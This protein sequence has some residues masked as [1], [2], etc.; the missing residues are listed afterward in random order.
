MSVK[1][2]LLVYALL[3]INHLCKAHLINIFIE[4]QLFKFEMTKG[5]EIIYLYEV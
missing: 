1:L 3:I 4:I 5:M 2:N